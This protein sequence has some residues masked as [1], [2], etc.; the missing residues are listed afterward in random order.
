MHCKIWW[1]NGYEKSNYR[2]II[3]ISFLDHKGYIQTPLTKN[4]KQINKKNHR[5]VAIAFIP[6]PENKPQVNH[7]NGNKLNN[8][9]ENLEWVTDKENK[10][11][12]KEAGLLYYKGF[13]GGGNSKLALND[14]DFIKNSLL[15]T[16][17][18][19]KIFKVSPGCIY[20]IREGYSWK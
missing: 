16:K 2:K 15:K 18:L 17:E 13:N 6:N 11:H 14:A 20:S 4:K 7:I 5:L 8:N 9:V 10:K 1:W 12:A 19:A 3:K